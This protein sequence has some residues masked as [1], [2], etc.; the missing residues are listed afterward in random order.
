[1]QAEHRHAA[2]AEA[3][4]ALRRTERDL[5]AGSPAPAAPAAAVAVETPRR[6]DLATQA[7][8]ETPATDGQVV[9]G[10]EDSTPGPSARPSS[11]PGSSLHSRAGS[12]SSYPDLTTARQRYGT[13]LA[14]SVRSAEVVMDGEA[15]VVVYTIH[16][17]NG[18]EEWTVMRRFRNFEALHRAMRDNPHY[19]YRLPPKRF[20]VH[21]KA[22]TH[23]ATD[24]PK[25]RCSFFLA[26]CSLALALPLS[27]SRLLLTDSATPVLSLRHLTLLV[28]TRAPVSVDRRPQSSSS[29]GRRSWTSTSGHCAGTRTYQSPSGLSGT[30]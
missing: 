20:L 7:G 29:H 17:S 9:G 30:S 27:P 21:T 26:S 24:Q 11:P 5:S 15:E 18:Q 3:A 12:R 4:E 16:A 23:A 22:S 1:M 25:N 14:A 8:A 13:I 2:S 6:D 19:R 10:A 28:L